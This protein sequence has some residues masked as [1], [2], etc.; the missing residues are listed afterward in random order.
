VDEVARSNCEGPSRVL[1]DPRR[2]CHS[3]MPQ[4]L[5][6]SEIRALILISQAFPP[7]KAIFTSVGVLLLVCILSNMFVSPVV[8]QS[9]LRQL[10]MSVQARTLFLRHSSAWK[11]FSNDWRFTLKR[12]WIKNG[13][14][15]DENNGG[16]AQHYWNCNKRNQARVYKYVFSVRSSYR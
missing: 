1:G 2:T 8:I 11:P 3:R 7:A 16:S 5:D 13:R 4:L 9:P 12:H 14:Y 10:R 15:S 6:L